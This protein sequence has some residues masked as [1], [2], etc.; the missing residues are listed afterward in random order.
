MNEES[1]TTVHA[2][3]TTGAGGRYLFI[4]YV[5]YQ[6]K[7]IPLIRYFTYYIAV[8]SRLKFC[9]VLTHWFPASWRHDWK[10][11]NVSLD[12]KYSLRKSGP[13]CAAADSQH[14]PWWAHFFVWCA[15]L[16]RKESSYIC[17]FEKKGKTIHSPLR[18]GIHF[19]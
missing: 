8:A 15:K 5:Y 16:V 6:I 13:I 10:T 1:D 18:I 11:C 17:L 14:S 12:E 4:I 7:W 19:S 9:V 3:N 2:Y